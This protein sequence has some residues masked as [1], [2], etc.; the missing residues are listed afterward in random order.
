[1]DT[2]T[3]PGQPAGSTETPNRILQRDPNPHLFR[4]IALRSVTA[5]NRIMVSPMCQY[6]ATDGVADDWHFQHLASR[7]VGGAGLVFT[8]VAHVEARGRITPYCLGLWNKA[9]RDALAR[10]VTFVKGQGAVAGIQV[11]HAG[12]KGSVARP[13]EGG[14]GLAPDAGGWEVI[15]PSPIPFGEGFPMPVEMDDR[16]IAA[17]VALFAQTARLAREA[18]FDVLE[19][20]GAHG[21]LIS[22]FL[23]PIANRRSDRYG[24]SFD[25]RIRFLLEV[26]DAVRAE[27]PEDRPLFLRI[28]CS[29]YMEGGS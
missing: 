11:G 8:E 13:W 7:A 12:R 29:D 28:S 3:A 6:S 25:N 16:A 24:G 5:R 26:L 22:E 20:H 23:S 19:V 14:K 1:M 2:K 15:A 21:Y 10:I 9:Q 27:W 4:P 18:G 17:A